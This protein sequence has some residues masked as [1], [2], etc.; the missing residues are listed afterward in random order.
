M[1][2]KFRNKY[3]I[4][5]TTPT[6]KQIDNWIDS[7]NLPMEKFNKNNPLWQSNYHDHII[8]NEIEYQQITNYILCN[9]MNWT[10]DTLKM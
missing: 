10:E 8:R 3:N 7:N 2:E 1:P 5:S 9:P 6:S 4:S